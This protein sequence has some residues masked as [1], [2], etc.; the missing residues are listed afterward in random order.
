MSS[1]LVEIAS[2]TVAAE[3]PFLPERQTRVQT[4]RRRFHQ[5]RKFTNSLCVGLEPEDCV[6]QSMPDVSP[7]KW[8][9]AHTSWFFEAFVA[10]PHLPDYSPLHPQY[11]FLFNSYYNAAGVKVQNSEATSVHSQ[12][13]L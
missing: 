10:K 3:R 2:A 7:P 6:V 9:L 8:H 13:R 4:L 5:I 1:P 12:L 11:A